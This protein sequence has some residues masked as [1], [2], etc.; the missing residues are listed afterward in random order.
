MRRVLSPPSTIWCWSEG[1]ISRP[2]VSELKRREA[3]SRRRSCQGSRSNTGRNTPCSWKPS[4]I[5][6]PRIR[7]RVSSRAT[8]TF[9]DSDMR[10]WRP[11]TGV[12]GKRNGAV[13]VPGLDRALG[14]MRWTQAGHHE[15]ESP[16]SALSSVLE[17]EQQGLNDFRLVHAPSGSA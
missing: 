5:W 13:V 3:M 12:D 8:L 6:A 2:T 15:H 11:A 17:L 9:L 4:R 16:T 14:Q 10:E 1:A 7:V